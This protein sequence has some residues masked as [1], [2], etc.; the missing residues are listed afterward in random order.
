[1]NNM[2]ELQLHEKLSL[3]IQQSKQNGFDGPIRFPNVTG[4][5]FITRKEKFETVFDNSF[6]IQ[7][8]SNEIE[9]I[10]LLEERQYTLYEN[11]YVMNKRF[12]DE[13]NNRHQSIQNMNYQGN[14][15]P[16]ADNNQN[17]HFV[18]DR[19]NL[20]P[21]NASGINVNHEEFINQQN[22]IKELEEN[23]K[24]L[25]SQNQ[26]FINDRQ[27]LSP[28][29][30]SGIN[31]NHEEFINQQNRIKELEEGYHNLLLQNQKLENGQQILSSRNA[32]GN[33]VNYKEII[34]QQNK[35]IKELEEGYNNLLSQNQKLES[36]LQ[37]LKNHNDNLK[38]EASKY[39]SA[40]GDATSFHLG[41]QNSD[42]TTRLSEDIGNLH[43]KLE[44]FCGLKK[45]I[46]V[47]EPEAKELLKK[48][49]C[50]IKGTMKEN[51]NLI[52]GALERNVIETI[53]EKA[54][55]YFNREVNDR[56]N[57]KVDEQGDKRQQNLEAKIVKTTEQ[58]LAMTN[59]F[60][61]IR[62][63]N[64]EVSKA[65]PTK[66]RQQIYGI[67]GNRGFSN[68][69]LD[70]SEKEHPFIEKLRKDILALMNRY[71]TIKDQEKLLENEKMINEIV[72]QVVN[73]F[74]FRLKV[75][76]PIAEW[77]WFPKSTGINTLTMEGSWDNDEL[78]DLYVD[79]CAFPLIGFNLNNA[80]DEKM[81]FPAQIVTNN[82]N[83]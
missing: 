67:L 71:R 1:M 6:H 13:C 5:Y 53:I 74:F 16:T 79:I 64:E 32:S 31:V 29:N 7:H 10:K 60:S 43:R 18:N 35:K 25:L 73:I 42:N 83:S 82:L 33:N 4:D 37:N 9:F 49:D 26:Q 72:R 78:E 15:Y 20:N 48:Y 23:N 56:D 68:T 52:S 76:E 8:V 36:V 11:Y 14:Y 3:A 40:L 75:Q 38:K 58:L 55:E 44:K 50:S 63:G 66:L 24:N 21:R 19:Q 39:Q 70:E 34:N 30:V 41:N 57:K 45:G 59:S 27:N 17:Q 2:L 69:V 51:K 62:T 54:A 22:R 12:Y 47:N 61:T 77:K 46:E 81:M 28:R 65:I 80:G